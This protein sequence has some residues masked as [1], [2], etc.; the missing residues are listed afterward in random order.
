MPTLARRPWV[1]PPIEDV[2]ARYAA[3]A[4]T[5]SADAVAQGYFAGEFADQKLI[6]GTGH[7]KATCNAVFRDRGIPIFIRSIGSVA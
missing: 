5:A 3:A 2:Q 4:A 6:Y 1:P 7:T